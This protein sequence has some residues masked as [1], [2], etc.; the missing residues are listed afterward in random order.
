MKTMENKNTKKKDNINKNAIT[1]D[2]NGIKNENGISKIAIIII[3]ILLVVLGWGGFFVFYLTTKTPTSNQP[4]NN[5]Q[6]T[7][8]NTNNNETVEQPVNNMQNE[9]TNAIEPIINLL[10]DSPVEDDENTE[11]I[12]QTFYYNQ[13][14]NYGK[15]IYDGLKENKEQLK[16]GNYEINYDTAFNTL[17]HMERGEEQLNEAF[18]SAWN[19]FSYDNTDL[20]YIDVS[21]MTLLKETTTLGGIETHRISIG[22]GQNSSYLKE[23]FNTEEKINTAE[24]YLQWI[25]DQVVEQTMQDDVVLKAEKVHNLLVSIID[26]E[27]S[28][29]NTNQ[30]TIYGALHDRKAVCEGYARAFKYLMEQINVPCVLV[31]GTATNSQGET[32]TH[33]WNYIQISNQWYAVDVTWDDPVIVGGGEATVDMMYQYFLKGSETF[34]VDHTEDGV[35]SEGSMEFSFPMLSVTDYPM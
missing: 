7:T 12:S 22:P 8:E 23:E 13:L 21:K 29:N 30:F 3:I 32:E 35:I 17:L 1:L 16:T 10:P 14:N 25:V 19:A 34:F 28:S 6:N 2:K 5:M 24:E 33:A 26:Y 18:Q 4:V 9:Q 15:I 27:D 20:F 31:S 11:L